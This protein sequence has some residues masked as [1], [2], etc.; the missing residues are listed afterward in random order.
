MC[1][2]CGLEFAGRIKDKLE[3][4]K[5]D[6]K[7]SKEHFVISRVRDIKIPTHP[8]RVKKEKRTFWIGPDW[9]FLGFPPRN[10]RKVSI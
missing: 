5:C 3:C 7:G 4:P 6:F 8:L 9:F 1:P 10:R 2:I